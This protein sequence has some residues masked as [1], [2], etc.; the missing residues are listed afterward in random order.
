M[1]TWLV[2]EDEPDLRAMFASATELI[3]VQTLIFADAESALAWI[4]EVEAGKRDDALP[5]L[6]LLDI[7]LG[8]EITGVMVGAKLRETPALKATRIVLMTAHPLTP[9]WEK[10]MLDQAG[11]DLLLYK[12]LPPFEDLHRL[13][14]TLMRR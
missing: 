5:D 1:T 9:A 14:Q 13:L 8:G 2:V 10:V 11:A 7:R 4:G 12:P 6:A 3:G